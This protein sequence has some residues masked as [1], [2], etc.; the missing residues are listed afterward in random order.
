M[1]PAGF[2]VL[3]GSDLGVT[4]SAARPLILFDGM[5]NL[6]AGSVR[7]VIARDPKARFTFA[8]LQSEYAKDLLGRLAP[9]LPGNALGR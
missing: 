1:D 2:A 9:G 8:S 5:C 4:D 7:F 3:R 6:C